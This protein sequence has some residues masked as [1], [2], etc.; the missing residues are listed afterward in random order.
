MA[1]PTPSL[2]AGWGVKSGRQT[3]KQRESKTVKIIRK[4]QQ[5]LR[6]L[7][8]DARNTKKNT[9]F[10]FFLVLGAPG[11]HFGALLE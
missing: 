7:K 5:I 1:G 8:K 9:I 3:E 11:T 2:A 4:T 10:R 6:K